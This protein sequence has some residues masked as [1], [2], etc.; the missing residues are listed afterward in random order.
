M[1]EKNIRRRVYDAL[2]VLLAIDVIVKTQS[3][4]SIEW[5]GLPVEMIPTPDKEF[6]L[7]KLESLRT[8]VMEKRHNLGCLTAQYVAKSRLISRNR[9]VESNRMR[10]PG[11]FHYSVFSDSISGILSSPTIG[12]LSRAASPSSCFA[13]NFISHDGSILELPFV[14]MLL[15]STERPESE[16]SHDSSCVN[17][18]SM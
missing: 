2:N 11:F 7:T 18:L 9:N 12:R 4:R 14:V 8:R 6:D 13:E 17:L 10:L 1:Q 5:K 3:Q 16:A 15:P